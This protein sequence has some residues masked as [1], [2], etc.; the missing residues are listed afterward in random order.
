MFHSI[1]RPDA[2]T[3]YAKTRFSHIVNL[4]VSQLNPSVETVGRVHPLYQLTS[5]QHSRTYPCVIDWIPF[6]S[7]RDK[8]ISLHSANPKLDEIFCDAVSSYVVE[9]DMTDLVASTNS[10]PVFVRVLDLVQTLCENQEERPEAR[11]ILAPSIKALFEDPVYASMAFQKL[12]VD[13]GISH[14][15]LDPAFF[16]KYPELYDGRVNIVAM[17][18]S[19]RPPKQMILSHPAPLEP[20]TLKTYRS[21]CDF[22]IES[23]YSTFRAFEHGLN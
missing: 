13:Q 16:Q 5:L 3:W 19:L 8:L 23:T 4:T 14:Y 17:G 20:G 2:M 22:T 12:Q 18:I 11:P 7:V 10:M 21:F 9:A 1:C 6:P 15:K